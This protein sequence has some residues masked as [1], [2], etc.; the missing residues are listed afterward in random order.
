LFEATTIAELSDRISSTQTS[1]S[2]HADVAA[3]LEELEQLSE[4]EA[5]QLLSAEVQARAAGNGQNA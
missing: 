4:E 5:Q 2:A 1:S 3:V